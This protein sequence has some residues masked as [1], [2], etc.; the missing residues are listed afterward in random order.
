MPS[1]KTQ[2]T[3]KRLIKELERLGYEFKMNLM[4]D[5]IEVSG[6][7]ITDPI[8]SKIKRD[9]R[10]LGY[11]RHLTAAKDAYIAYAYEHS[12]HPIQE[13]LEGL[14]WDGIPNIQRLATYF[15]DTPQ[16]NCKPNGGIFYTFFNRFVIGSV[17]KVLDYRQNVMLVI[18]GPQ[19][20]GKSHFVRWL[21]SGVPPLF[22]LEK[23]INPQDKDD[24]IR[25][26]S[27]FI[28]EVAELGATARRADRESLKHFIS[29]RQ[30]T[31]RKPYGYYDIVKPAM[32]NLIGTINNEA[33]FLTDPTGNRR[34][35]VCTIQ[36]IDW[37]YLTN[38]SVD[39]IWAEAVYKYKNGIES[40][41]LT[42]TEQEL[43][44]C[45]NEAYMV[46]DPFIIGLLQKCFANPDDTS[47][48]H[49]ASSND[50]LQFLGYNPP[51]R[52]DT[53]ALASAAKKIGL[54]KGK[55]KLTN[56]IN[57]YYGVIIP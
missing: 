52:G 48:D 18:D 14:K 12:Y 25:L 5:S 13:Y 15:V 38:I 10:D 41:F 37:D 55:D 56:K 19:G 1:Q 17:A 31:V 46:D 9:L 4:N 43:Q 40:E 20:I 8:E 27:K 39:Q 2:V 3:S 26:I 22:F 28:W 57:G 35:L 23:A 34:F 33:G 45:L 49:W 36:A 24:E 47:L 29:V 6:V 51:K 53:M 50:I 54:K 7:P 30:V 44:V 16:D 11:N 21:A 32:A 42:E